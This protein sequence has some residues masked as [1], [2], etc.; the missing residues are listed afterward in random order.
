MPYT[1]ACT[2][3]C[4]RDRR[5]PQ[6]QDSLWNGEAVLQKRNLLPEQHVAHTESISVAVADGVGNSPRAELASLCVLQALANEAPDT[7]FDRRMVVRLHDQLCQRLAR[8][9]TYGSS[10][11]LAAVRCYPDHCEVL[12]AGDSRVY[13]ISTA[14]AWQQLSH[15]H[16]LINSLIAQGEAIAGVEYATI[17][18]ML[19]S[20]LVADS[21]ECEFA[22]HHRIE[23]MAV[24]DTLLLCTDGVH[25]T[26]SDAQLQSLFNPNLSPKEQ[27]QVWRDAVLDAGAPDNLSLI[28]V[29]YDARGAEQGA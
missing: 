20:C 24:G 26:L 16:S 10:T 3:H 18:D 2:Q 11:T 6:Q 29:R 21:D 1:I 27:A 14:G 15:D 28:V 25:D 22:I 9:E 19:D 7:P 12:N 23:P 4:G 17:Y 5:F 8:G 13:R